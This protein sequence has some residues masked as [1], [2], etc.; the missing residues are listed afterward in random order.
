M[1]RLAAESSDMASY[2]IPGSRSRWSWC[3]S[4]WGCA[5]SLNALAGVEGKKKGGILTVYVGT[6]LKPGVD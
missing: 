1:G 4:L 2:L 6:F 5:W 3:L